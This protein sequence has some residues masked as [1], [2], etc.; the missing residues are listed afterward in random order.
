MK[1]FFKFFLTGISASAVLLSCG[2][3][4]TEEVEDTVAVV[5]TPIQ[6]LMLDT[7]GA[8]SNTADIGYNAAEKIVYVPTFYKNKVAAYRLDY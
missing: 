4:K 3:Q 1:L 7:K 6:T 5:K 2:P 8:E